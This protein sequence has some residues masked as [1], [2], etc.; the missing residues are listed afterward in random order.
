MALFNLGM[1]L[2]VAYATWVDYCFF[3]VFQ[4]GAFYPW[5]PDR[6]KEERVE[7][8]R[9]NERYAVFHQALSCLLHQAP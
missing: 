1:R 5:R 9:G 4:A 2:W 3:S 8:L 7:L 6:A